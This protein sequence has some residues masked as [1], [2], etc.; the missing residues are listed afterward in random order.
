MGFGKS[1]A[2]MLTEKQGKVT[3]NDVAGID[4]A[5]EELE[6]IVDFLKDPSSSRARRQD[7][8]GRLAGR[9]ARHRQDAARPR[10]RG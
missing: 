1:R 6:E 5:R 2:R 10:H 3:F 8:Q 4:E 7:P 9:L